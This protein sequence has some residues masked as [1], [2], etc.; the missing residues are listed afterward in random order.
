MEGPK[1]K[2]KKAGRDA[3]KPKFS[4]KLQCETDV[5]SEADCD[6]K[7]FRIYANPKGEGYAVEER[8]RKAGED[9]RNDERRIRVVNASKSMDISK[10]SLD[11]KYSQTKG[12]SSSQK[13]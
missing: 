6:I 9:K 5:I 4:N 7:S 8:F 2:D 10:R 11:K 13:Q 1:G 12:K 3:R